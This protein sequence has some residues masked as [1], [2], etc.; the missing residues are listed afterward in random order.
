[1]TEPLDK[2]NEMRW[3]GKRESNPRP[4]PWQGNALPAELF[5]RKNTLK[6]V[7]NQSVL[8]N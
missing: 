6:M 1:M 4:L 5:P 7:T 8:S 2:I 3:S